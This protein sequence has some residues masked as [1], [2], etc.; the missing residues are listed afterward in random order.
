MSRAAEAFYHLC[1]TLWVGGMLAIGYLVAPVMFQ[2][3]TDR[4]LAGTVAGELFSLFAWVGLACG[5]YL[6]GFMR[7]RKGAR[8][9]QSQIFW[10]VLI[11]MVLV[12][13]GKFGVQPVLAQ[14]KH[15]ALP[16][17]VMESTLRQRFI[18]WHGISSGL[19]LVQSL[20][21]IV[22]VCW[23]DRGKTSR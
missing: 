14:L 7:V 18:L 19:F 5:I 22:L 12:I 20:F 2:Q 10:V 6:L 4:A 17:P 1:I 23:Q 9:M 13:A 8:A 21:G 15:D 3:V 11:M 16:M